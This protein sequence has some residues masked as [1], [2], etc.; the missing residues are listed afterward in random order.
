MASIYRRA[1]SRFWWATITLPNGKQKQLSTKLEDADDAKEFAIRLEG[2][3]RRQKGEAY[4]RKAL[5]GIVSSLMGS[6]QIGCESFFL[7]WIERRGAEVEDG[8]RGAYQT[9]VN[10]VIAYAKD[11]GRETL[12]EI[13][14]NDVLALR[15][16]WQRDRAPATTN[17]K[18]KVLRMALKDAWKARLV[19]ENVA[20]FVENVKKE[21]G[22][23]RR[24]F[25]PAEFKLVLKHCDATWRAFTLLGLYTGG[26]R[27]GDLAALR[28]KHVNLQ[29]K[30]INTEA[31]KTRA[32]IILP[33][34]PALECALLEL[35]LPDDP[36]AFLFPELA[37]L[38]PGG[39]SKRFRRILYEAGLV[40]RRTDQKTTGKG[41]ASGR[42]QV[43]ELTFHS[44]RH[45]ATTMLK[46]AGVSDAVARS[47]VGHESAAI[48]KT[49]THMPMEAMREALEKVK[50]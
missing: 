33:V 32:P 24:D 30:E 19:S 14:V 36:E 47:I 49:Y 22:S 34:V 6:E 38:S 1:R 43:S 31:K 29:T 9:A 10:E 13:S 16:Q 46:A 50:I 20:D 18:L 41:K 42:R 2:E 23:K 21:R 35:G 4:L 17:L 28:R 45:T 40:G 26:Q 15:T 39:R 12:S 3:T 8:T 11:H 7:A 25:T 37:A 48:S 5:S 44:M 27:M